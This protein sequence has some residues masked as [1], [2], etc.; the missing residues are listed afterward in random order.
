MKPRRLARALALE[1]LYEAEVSHHDP[2]EVF[3][4][5]VQEDEH[6][7]D[8]A[9]FARRLVEGVAAHAQEIDG[10]ISRRAPGWP[11]AQVAPIDVSILRLG[12]FDLLYHESPEK[13][14]INE[15]VELAKLYGG[16]SSQRFINGVLGAIARGD[17]QP[18]KPRQE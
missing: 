6:A 13:V 5:R 11:L 18:A 7:A 9:G 14:A 15:A 1:V 17:A 8:V 4:R 12:A 3:E 16:D 10:E 2:I